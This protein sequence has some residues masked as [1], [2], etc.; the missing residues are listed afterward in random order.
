MPKMK[1]RRI[2]APPIIPIN[3]D[4]YFSRD[5]SFILMC[6]LLPDQILNTQLAMQIGLEESIIITQYVK[7]AED[8]PEGDG[9]FSLEKEDIP[10]IFPF[11][12]ASI[13][14]KENSL[15]A[16]G[17]LVRLETSDMFTY[18]VQYDKMTDLMYTVIGENGLPENLKERY[19]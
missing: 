17:L 3:R 18:L 8:F 9:W 16:K 13:K 7:F 11:I 15:I 5:K 14:D 2:K 6:R 12:K 19:I 1:K 10:Y 4:R